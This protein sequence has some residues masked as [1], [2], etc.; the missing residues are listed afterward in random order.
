[1][2]ENRSAEDKLRKAE[3]K[4]RRAEGKL[5]RAEENSE[6]QSAL[7]KRPSENPE[8]YQIHRFPKLKCAQIKMFSNCQL[9]CCVVAKPR[10]IRYE[11]VALEF[12][13]G[14]RI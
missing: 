8:L 14:I 3:G 9:S 6:G 1:M 13:T 11:F 7:L 5:R 12:M 2:V 10:K 4:L